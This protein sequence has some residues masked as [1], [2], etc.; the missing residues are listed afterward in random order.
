MCVIVKRNSIILFLKLNCSP[1]CP[2]CNN[3]FFS[4][5]S[6]GVRPTLCAGWCCFKGLAFALQHYHHNYHHLFEDWHCELWQ[7]P[8]RQPRCSRS[9]REGLQLPQVDPRHD[10]HALILSHTENIFTRHVSFFI[11]TTSAKAQPALSLK[12]DKLEIYLSLIIFIP[13][14]GSFAA[15]SAP[16]L[17]LQLQLHDGATSSN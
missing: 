8:L 13:S 14:H 3:S 7:P 10:R 15:F 16:C 2:P 6:N 5:L 1:H 4:D 17:S 12:C 9:V 11:S